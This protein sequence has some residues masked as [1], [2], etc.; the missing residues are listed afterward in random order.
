MSRVTVVVAILAIALAVA[1]AGCVTILKG[2]SQ[3][4]AITSEPSGA[5]VTVG[6][7]RVTTPAQVRLSRRWKYLALVRKDGYRPTRA[8]IAEAGREGVFWLNY[9]TCALFCFGFGVDAGLSYRL[10]PTIHVVLEPD[11]GT[12]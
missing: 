11:R 6:E 4:V 2:R 3:V 10:T 5:S 12:P 9:F 7:H 8:V 1:P